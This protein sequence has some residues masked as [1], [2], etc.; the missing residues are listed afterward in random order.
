MKVPHAPK[1]LLMGAMFWAAPAYG[2]TLAQLT[3]ACVGAGGSARLCT[4]AAV[5]A[6]TLC[7]DIVGTRRVVWATAGE[8]AGGV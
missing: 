3:T 5:G 7:V 8:A 1:V 6:Q 4:G 2:Q